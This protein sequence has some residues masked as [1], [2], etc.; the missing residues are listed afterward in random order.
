MIGS[1]IFP[2]PPPQSETKRNGAGGAGGAGLIRYRTRLAG[3]TVE[4]EFST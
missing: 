2:T 1:G 4:E 3:G